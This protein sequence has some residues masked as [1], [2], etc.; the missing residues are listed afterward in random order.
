MADLHRRIEADAISL[1]PDVV[2]MMIGINDTWFSFSRW[3]DTSVTAFKEVYRV[4]LNRIK[5]R[6][7]CGTDFDGAVCI[8]ISG[9]P[10]SVAW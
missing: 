9:R 3:E 5:T 8:T 7:K 4:I 10:E 1:Q 6:N 2:T